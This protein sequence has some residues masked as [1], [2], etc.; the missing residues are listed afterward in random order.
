VFG[1]IDNTPPLWPKIPATSDERALSDAMLDYWTS[2]AKSGK[3][4]A[5]NAP[6]WPAYG[7]ATNYM[8]FAAT[9]QPDTAL[10][11]GMFAFNETVMCRKA[12]AK[13][14]WNWNIGLNAPKLPGKTEG[15]E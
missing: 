14:G 6:A 12:K 2:F 7:K 5:A 10:M 4:T 15:C 13:I 8:H 11:P 3:P 9:P 1:T